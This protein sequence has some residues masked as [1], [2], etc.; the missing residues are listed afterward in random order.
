MTLN[1]NSDKDEIKS[2]VNSNYILNRLNEYGLIDIDTPKDERDTVVKALYSGDLRYN[3]EDGE[4]LLFTYDR[5]TKKFISDKDYEIQYSLPMVIEDNC[6][7]L[8][9][10]RHSDN[11]D[12]DEHYIVPYDKLDFL[13]DFNLIKGEW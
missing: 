2:W 6:F 8:F 9:E 13:V 1:I 10:H 4:M 7:V 5:F 3:Y 12:K 11:E